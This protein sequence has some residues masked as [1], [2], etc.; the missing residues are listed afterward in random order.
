MGLVLS[1]EGKIWYKAPCHCFLVDGCCHFPVRAGWS[2]FFFC[3]SKHSPEAAKVSSRVL[4]YT[5]G[6]RNEMK[7]KLGVSNMPYDGGWW[8]TDGGWWVTDGS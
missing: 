6:C 7:K 4:C 1:I 2:I 3:S 5:R 8:V